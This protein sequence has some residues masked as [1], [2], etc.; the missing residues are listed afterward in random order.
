MFSSLLVFSG[1]SKE[2]PYLASEV[3]GDVQMFN[4]VMTFGDF[5]N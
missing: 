3:T 2:V 5:E 1:F 4:F